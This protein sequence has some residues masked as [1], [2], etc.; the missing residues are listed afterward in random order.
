MRLIGAA[1][2]LAAAAAQAQTINI[3]QDLLAAARRGSLEEVGRLLDQG[4]A[5][6]SKNRIGDTP[7]I[8]A[9]KNGKTALALLLLQRG[10]D[11]NQADIAGISQIGQ[12]V[13]DRALK[14]APKYGL[15]L[16]LPA[17]A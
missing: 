17:Q 7:L 11:A 5:I 16:L 4:A 6:N 9:A 3:N 1:L 14:T 10:A 8:M 15:E 2:V 12:A 13:I